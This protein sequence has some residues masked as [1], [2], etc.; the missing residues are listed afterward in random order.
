M[1]NLSSSLLRLFAGLVVALVVASVSTEAR[2][3]KLRDIA[4]VSGARD[5]QLVGFGVVTGLAGTGD[6]SSAPIAAKAT[7]EMLRRLGISVD[8]AQVKLKNVAAV[9]VTATLPP[10]AKSGTKLDI[11]V[12][13]IGNAKSLAGGTLVQSLLKGADQKTYAV[14]QGA[15]IV[16]SGKDKQSTTT[17]ARIP[18]G[19]LVERE[20]PT[21]ISSGG[22]I[23]LSLRSPSFSTATNL[24]RA[25]DQSIG[26][27]SAHAKDG[28][29][30]IVKIP[31]KFKDDTVGLI[32]KLEDI[33]V[34]TV[35]K[36]RVV[37]NE[38]T[39][40]I[41][42]GGDVRLAPAAI[43]HGGLTIVVKD[44]AAP[45]PA[46]APAPATAAK[47]KGAKGKQSAAAA[48]APA[49]PAAPAPAAAPGVGGEGAPVRYLKG[50]ASLSDVAA[51][52]GTL[53]LSA[54]D[55][56]SVLSTLRTAGALEAE[57]VIE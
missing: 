11:T 43:V 7:I 2:A 12:S 27:G 15:L 57:V 48:A 33:E 24:V 1:K 6:D 25:I 36:A 51:A 4:E 54:R 8:P 16:G 42:A 56:A 17:A 20:V 38:K 39:G 47:G 19:A 50:A 28:G 31:A 21:S 44:P 32:A 13:S 46:A 29:S 5:N 49:A 55:L 3:D 34:A 10:F 37:I 45:R 18:G 30:V 23:S 41:V 40:T 35:K 9:V 26:E 14:A 53:G 52:L 22:E